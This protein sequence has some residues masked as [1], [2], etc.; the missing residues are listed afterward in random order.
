MKAIILAAGVGKRMKSSQ[1]KPLLPLFGMPIIEHTIRKIKDYEIIVVYHDE[2][3]KDFLMKKFPNIKFVYN[4]EPEREN[5]WSLYLAR[6][7]VDEDFLLLM[8]DHY[9]GENFFKFDKKRKTTVFVS[10]YCKDEEE[11]TKVK[12]KGKKVVSIGKNLRE[13]DYFDTGFFYCKKE[14]FDYAEKLA[15][16]GKMKLAEIIQEASKDGKIGYEVIDDKWIDIDTKDDLKEAEKIVGESLI[17][18]KD[19]IISKTINRRI[20]IRITKHLLKYESLTPNKMTVISFLMGI[21]SAFL[22]LIQKFIFAGITAQFCSIIDGCDGEIARVKNIKTKFGAVFDALL[23]RYT[24]FFIIFAMFYAYGINS[25]SS[26]ALFL[27]LLGCILPSYTYHLTG[28]RSKFF[29]RDV[30]LFIVM[31]AGLMAYISKEFLL[32]SL[33]FLGLFMNFGATLNMIIYWKKG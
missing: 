5:G 8:A 7:F 11:A 15:K 16:K 24:D 31:L 4:P 14:I 23:D 21:L 19:G 6:D 12:V 2:R 9:Y 20:S 3:I 13:Y 32:Y 29:G 25:L 33:L 18:E 30:R 10:K 26:F 22:F 17:K 27:A 28:V 1:P